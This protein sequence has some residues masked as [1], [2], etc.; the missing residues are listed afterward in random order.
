MAHLFAIRLV[1]TST[2]A[3]A[4][5]MLPTYALDRL[6]PFATPPHSFIEPMRALLLHEVRGVNASLYIV[7]HKELR[8]WCEGFVISIS[9]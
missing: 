9:R 1:S 2:M 5:A 4:M 6:A 7:S 8:C 3:G